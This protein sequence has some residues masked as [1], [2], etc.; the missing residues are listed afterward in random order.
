MMTDLTQ[1]LPVELLA[2]ILGHVSVLD[3]LRLE[4]VWKPPLICGRV[5]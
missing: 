1:K 5:N 2:E 4:Q 3:T